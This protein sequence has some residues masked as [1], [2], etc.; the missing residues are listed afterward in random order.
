MTTTLFIA[1]VLAV[2]ATFAAALVYANRSTSD[3]IAPGGRPL[4]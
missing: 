2:F 3:I 1:A 4:D